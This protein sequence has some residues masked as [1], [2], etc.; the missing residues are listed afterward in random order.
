MATQIYVNTND[1]EKNQCS[2]NKKIENFPVDKKLE[3]QNW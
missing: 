1:Q 3:I 2:R